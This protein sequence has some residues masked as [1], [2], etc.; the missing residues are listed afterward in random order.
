MLL[1]TQYPPM[2]RT[3]AYATI[4][5][6]ASRYSCKTNT[7]LYTAW[8]N[9]IICRLKHAGWY[10]NRRLHASAQTSG[11]YQISPAY[12]YKNS[13]RF[14]TS[15]NCRQLWNTQTSSRTKMV[16]ASSTIPITLYS[17]IQFLVEY[18]GTMVLRDI[19]KK[20][21]T[22]LIQKCERTNYSYQTIC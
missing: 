9:N 22:W 15:F 8:H 18:G 1:C 11:I 19:N 20:N 2:R 14:G 17:N 3:G 5:S 6:L 16:K 12:R 4:T 21:P 13:T 10:G 7:R